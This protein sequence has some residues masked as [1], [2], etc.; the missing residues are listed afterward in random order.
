MPVDDSDQA[1][2]SP[3]HRH[4]GDFCTPDLD[5][6]RNRQA[7]QE[8]GIALMSHARRNANSPGVNS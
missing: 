3:P 8:I 1:D 7:A 4:I 5:Y 6:T 2:E